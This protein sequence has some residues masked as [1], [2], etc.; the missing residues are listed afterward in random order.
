[1]TTPDRPRPGPG[2]EREH[3]SE[4]RLTDE[5]LLRMVTDADA[6]LE[7]LHTELSRR[8]HDGARLDTEAAQHAE[9]SRL[10]EHLE[11]AQVDWR[12]VR[13]FFR[14]AFMESRAGSPWGPAA[15]G[16]PR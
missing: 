15:G 9:I 8:L 10:A 12:Q 13:E 1:M 2:Q 6:H 4:R 3:G 5:E 11:R 14:D 7:R 16:D